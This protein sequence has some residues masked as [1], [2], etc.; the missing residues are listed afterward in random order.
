MVEGSDWKKIKPLYSLYLTD[1]RL[2]SNSS[3]ILKNSPSPHRH[4]KMGQEA[5]ETL[6]LGQK[7]QWQT[8]HQYLCPHYCTVGLSTNPVSGG[9]AGTDCEWEG[10]GQREDQGVC[11]VVTQ[12]ALNWTTSLNQFRFLF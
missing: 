7:W 9:F 3:G 11:P 8:R 5:T 12:V 6:P 1:L 10:L 4:L 2:L